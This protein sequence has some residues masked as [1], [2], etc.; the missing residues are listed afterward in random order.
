MTT[1]EMVGR[2]ADE[3]EAE[4]AKLKKLREDEEEGF[5]TDLGMTDEEWDR[6][7]RQMEDER[8]SL[9][10]GWGG[11]EDADGSDDDEEGGEAIEP[12]WERVT[13][14]LDSGVVRKRWSFLGA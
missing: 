8:D 11:E 7:E 12:H 3:I 4:V 6:L 14:R 5:P 10:A 13:S 1:V 9:L 2:L